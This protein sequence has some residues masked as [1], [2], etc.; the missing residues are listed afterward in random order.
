M[1]ARMSTPAAATPNVPECPVCLE[2]M[3]PPT[4]IFNCRNGHLI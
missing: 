3:N 4:E 2:E 1:Q